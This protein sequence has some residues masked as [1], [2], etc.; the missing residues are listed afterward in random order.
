MQ[1]FFNLCEH[2]QI[3]TS[4]YDYLLSLCDR[5]SYLYGYRTDDKFD[6]DIEAIGTDFE[7]DIKDIINKAVAESWG[8]SGAR[9]SF[10]MSDR[11]KSI[12]TEYGLGGIIL[13]NNKKLENLSLYNNEK[14][15]YSVCS[16]EGYESFDDEFKNIVS[17]FCLKKAAELPVYKELDNKFAKYSFAKNDELSKSFTILSELLNY[18]M[19]ACKAVI[20]GMP[21]Y[22]INY[23]DYVALAEKFLSDDLVKILKKYKSF[24]QLH[25]AGYPQTFAEIEKFANV[26]GFNCSEIYVELMEQLDILKAVWYNHRVYL[27][28]EREQINPTIVIANK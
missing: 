8:M 22:E 5:V 23:E 11:V 25:P 2:S 12:I 6:F 14:L 1:N 9:Y 15:L 28:S 10:M 7:N 13:V 27:F 4:A 17:T 3:R 19:Q 21:V 24:D 20:H 18:V 26:Q 16:H